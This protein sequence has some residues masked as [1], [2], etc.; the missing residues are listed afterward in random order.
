[1]GGNSCKSQRERERHTN[2]QCF[3]ENSRLTPKQH[4]P[5]SPFQYTSSL[6]LSPL[7]FLLSPLFSFCLIIICLI[8]SCLISLC[9]FTSQ[10]VSS[11]LNLTSLYLFSSQFILRNQFFFFWYQL[12]WET[13]SF[14]FS[15]CLI[16]FISSQVVHLSS[17]SLLLSSSS[18]SFVFSSQFPWPLL[19]SSH[20]VSS[21]FT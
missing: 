19:L 2:T 13:L 20:F 12:R 8:S 15:V 9:L 11:Y 18:S 4:S 7:P 17:L 6:D 5:S 10:F 14:L 3:L 1:M 16:F 21:Y